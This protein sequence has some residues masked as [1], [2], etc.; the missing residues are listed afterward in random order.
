MLFF[1]IALLASI[2]GACCGLG[3]GVII[4]PLLDLFTDFSPSHISVLSAFSVLTI[5]VTSVIKYTFQKTKFNVLRCVFIGVGGIIGGFAGT[6]TLDTLISNADPSHVLAI[7]SLLTAL[8]LSAAVLYML[9]IK[10]KFSLKITNKAAVLLA[11]FVLGFLSALLSIGGGPINV[12]LMVILFSANMSEAAVS[13][14]FV[15]VLSQ[16]TK[17]ITVIASD[18]FIGAD[19][20]PLWILIPTAFVGAIFGAWLNKK[21]K[22]KTVV[23][24]YN[25]TVCLLVAI[26]IYNAVSA[27]LY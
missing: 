14:L 10:E 5:A 26:N 25:I 17:I 4:K 8:L 19:L 12:A 7:Q 9:F 1:I 18:G 15:I 13:S 23:L 24:M 22:Q 16:T 11:G 21:L 20:S 6:V 2:I 27:I 3:G